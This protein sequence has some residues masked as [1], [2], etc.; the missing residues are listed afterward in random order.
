MRPIFPVAVRLCLVLLICVSR[1]NSEPP[2]TGPATEAR[3]PP[4]RVPDGF[5]AT[6]FAC[7]PLVEYP[8]AVAL[9]PRPGTLFVAADYLTGLGTEIV[10]RDEI[11]LI[12]DVDG[13]GYADRAAVFADGFN[14]IQGLTWHDG[15]V[16]AMHAP[17]LTAL[18]DA[19]GDGRADERQ[20][21]L[22]G[23][24]L[25]L[26]ENPVRLHCANGV[27]M[28]HDGWLYLALGDHGCRVDR[29]EGDLLVLE[30][31]GIL[32]CRP[33][34]RDLHV[35]AT[36]L[37]NI[38]DVALDD[39]LNVFVRDN[40]NDGGDYKIRVC[41][42]FFGA[43]HGYPYR[44][45]ERPDEALPPLADLGLGSSAGGLCYLESQFPAEYRGNLFFCEWGKSVV[46][47][48]PAR[49]GGGFAPLVEHEFATGAD[50]DSYGFKPTDLVVDRDGALF[51][52]DWADGQQPKRGR[53]RVYRIAYRG[54]DAP[55]PALLPPEADLET[56]LRHL[57]S[58]SYS[59][60]VAAQ[61][62]LQ[63]GG[64][65]AIAALRHS[66][67]DRGLDP[68][69]RMHAIWALARAQGRVA[70]DDLLGLAEFEPD[71]RVRAQAIRALADLHDPVLV[72]RRLDAEPR[73]AVVARRLAALADTSP[74][75]QLE[76]TIALGR[77]RWPDAPDWLRRTL[78]NPDA[79]LAHAAL[80]TL[81]RSRNWPA[82]LELV[83]LPDD[84]PLRGIA[85]RA[86]AEQHEV[87]L[88][89]GLLDR[90]QREPAA[91]RRT[92]L[93]DLL[94]RVYKRPVPWT[95]WDYRP[96]PRPVN[97]VA[98]ERTE[99]IEGA[100]DR[101]LADEEHA[102][103][104]AALRRMQREQVP[105]RASTLGTWLREE[106]DAE[107]LAAILK[108]LR[109]HPAAEI[110]EFLA[111][112]VQD[113]EKPADIRVA[114][115]ELLVG[116]LQAGTEERLLAVA[117]TLEDGPLLAAALRQLGSRPQL[118]AAALLLTKL[119]SPNPAVRTAAIEALTELRVAES[120]ASVQGL[121]TDEEAAVRRAAAR[122]MGILH[123]PGAAEALLRLAR[124]GDSS[125]RRA[126]LESL[127]LLKEKRVVPAAVDALDDA[128]TRAAGLACLAEFGGEEQADAVV[129]AARV[130]SSASILQLALW[131]LT[132]WG[133][134]PG[135]NPIRL[136][137]AVAELQ[138][139]SGMLARWRVAG[140]MSAAA[141]AGI[142]EQ[143]ATPATSE[144]PGE[145]SS[146]WATAFGSG[147]DARVS[148]SLPA[149]AAPEG[150]YVARSDF[151]LP[152]AVDVE[153][154]AGGNSPLRVWLNGVLAYE[155]NEART[156]LSG[157]DRFPAAA[158]TGGNRVLIQLAA[159]DS[160]EFQIQF[161]RR[162]SSAEQERLTE[163]ALTT[164]GDA[165]R[166]RLLFFDAG[167]TQ[168]AKCHRIGE[169]GERI[170]PELTGVGG[171]FSR[172]HIVESILQPSRIIAPSYQ[173]LTVLL[174]DGLLVTGVKLAETEEHL[175]LGDQRGEK[176][177]L[178]K[179]DI[180]ERQPQ[181]TSVMP[182]GLER[183]LTPQQFVDL[184]T[185]L[186]EQ[187]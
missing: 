50:N 54:A 41:H 63:S 64:E 77:L 185:F 19:D 34:G 163:A 78:K 91:G 66:L 2:Q 83:D 167:K 88:V 138:G 37:R 108:S 24:G 106:A 74:L 134:R 67:T 72:D 4:L 52:V 99:A 90:L 43:D 9:G 28:G 115:L 96:A 109:I 171:R 129:A 158:M 103:R 7:D 142:V 105:T 22:A 174:G 180:E 172:I 5:Q 176:H 169:Q 121:L 1:A 45:Y 36:G 122:A 131:M 53:G 68:L 175:T 116:G 20:D 101:V 12:E 114:A 73:D 166:G 16:Y 42:S 126:S 178:A 145:D 33:D 137:N 147:T 155:R 173:T 135:S 162:S 21:L 93:A 168:C 177:V 102:V 100:L 184:L 141:A 94:T 75:M 58:T 136:E 27:T 89:D 55:P 31:G 165:D 150:V 13:D 14:S 160:V 6:L 113:A 95:Y 84:D 87:Q 128:T 44:Y 148:L 120:A 11:R 119:A 133:E 104:F 125:V 69:G 60:R 98:W 81:R 182:D 86:V 23:L 152:A 110:R 124:D 140:P 38:Y 111:A 154:L 40:E 161:R 130:D 62:S 181:T 46:R 3:F 143:W 151:Q 70:T 8:S 59:T 10:R 26:E 18:R 112:A 56:L 127:L 92:A 17:Q 80:W 159:A 107:H 48:A 179:A 51:V 71:V 118:D 35:F 82:L 15:V 49:A 32:R 47:Y 29:P 61:E 156:S 30:G 187:K 65:E 25:P 76:T 123:I 183:Q 117:G 97:S 153:F 146:S 157:G 149:G 57:D 85:L 79:A 170:G 39:G 144:S 132:A 186:V 164:S 139:D